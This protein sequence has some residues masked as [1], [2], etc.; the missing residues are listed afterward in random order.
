V[1]PFTSSMTPTWA[2]CATQNASLLAARIHR[3]IEAGLLFAIT[4][5]GLHRLHPHTQGS[6][7]LEEAQQAERASWQVLANNSQ[8]RVP[9]GSNLLSAR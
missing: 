7:F 9:C 5:A 1:A 2:R 6:A 4:G 3:L 8:Q